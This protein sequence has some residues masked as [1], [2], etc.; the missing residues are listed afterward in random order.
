MLSS[1]RADSYNGVALNSPNDAL[2]DF[3]TETLYFTNLPFGH[4]LKSSG[5]AAVDNV[6]L[7]MTQDSIAIYIIAGD[8]D[9]STPVEPSRVLDYVNGTANSWAATYGVALLSNGDLVSPITS[10]E[11]PRFEVFSAAEKSA[12]G[13]D[14]VYNP[15]PTR[16]LESEYRIEGENFRHSMMALRIR[17]NTTYG[18]VQVPVVSTK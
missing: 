4:H 3:E 18:S 15:S 14:V 8:P 7:N 17:P 9:T 5:G 16:R 13:A 11:D 12:N 6:F 10:F 2:L 1:W